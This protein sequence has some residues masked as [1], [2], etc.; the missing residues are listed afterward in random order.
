MKAAVHIS[1][2]NWARVESDNWRRTSCNPLPALYRGKISPRLTRV[3]RT[4]GE[5]RARPPAERHSQAEKNCL[6]MKK[7]K[8][9]QKISRARPR[10]PNEEEDSSGRCAR[11]H[12]ITRRHPRSDSSA[13]A[14]GAPVNLLFL[15]AEQ[16][17]GIYLSG[18]SLAKAEPQPCWGISAFMGRA[19]CR[20]FTIVIGSSFRSMSD[21]NS[22]GDPVYSL[23]SIG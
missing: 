14:P 11:V 8:K 18:E 16:A 17:A 7:K 1:A 12:P 22:M 21:I 20:L 3:A 2:W 19:G 6:R 13:A 10:I 9:K 15:L 5:K 23:G 4:G